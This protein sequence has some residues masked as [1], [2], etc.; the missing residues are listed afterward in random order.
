VAQEI[1]RKF[2]VANDDWRQHVTGSFVLKQGY[3]S[4]TPESSVRIRIKGKKAMLTVKGKNQGIRR[5]E[6]EY[7]IPIVDAE[8]MLLLCEGPLIS[9]TRHLINQSTHTWEIDEF[10]D[11]NKGL[12][13]A[14]IEL[15][16]EKEPFEKPVWL[17]EEVSDDERYYNS[18]LVA[19]PYTRW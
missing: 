5:T 6:F 14:E 10:A 16:T 3:L 15:R 18:N 8:A 1:E 9:K 12:I 19:H 7:E 2:L 4:T 11:D 17:G 13:I